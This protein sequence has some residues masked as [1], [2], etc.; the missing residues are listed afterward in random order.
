MAAAAATP[1]ALPDC[2]FS[3]IYETGQRE[4]DEKG[5]PESS[6]WAARL[7][8]LVTG[9]SDFHGHPSHRASTL[10][11]VTLPQEDYARLRDRG[12]PAGGR[13]S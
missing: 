5:L 3:F 4:M 2:D 6:E 11:Q 10:G 12:W 9:G 7:G 8:L 13:A 1:A